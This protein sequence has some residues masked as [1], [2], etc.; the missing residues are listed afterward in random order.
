MA[1]EQYIVGGI[2]HFLGRWYTA[3]FGEYT[4]NQD[5]LDKVELKEYVDIL[6]GICERI[7]ASG[8]PYKEGILYVA[9]HYTK[10]FDEEFK[11]KFKKAHEPEFDTYMVDIF[12]MKGC[13]ASD[14]RY[15]ILDAVADYNKTF[16]SYSRNIGKEWPICHVLFFLTKLHNCISN[17]IQN[18]FIRNDLKYTQETIELIFNKN[19]QTTAVIA[20]HFKGLSKNGFDQ[21][22]QSLSNYTSPQPVTNTKEAEELKRKEAE[23]AEE[24]RK[25]A[26]E[27]KKKE[28]KQ[29]EADAQ[30][31]EERRRK[32]AEEQIRKE[33]EAKAAEEEERKRKEAEAAERK[34]KQA[35][36]LKQKEDEAAEEL[37]QQKQKEAKAKAAEEEK[38]K[39]KEAEAAKVIPVPQ[40]EETEPVIEPNIKKTPRAKQQSNTWTPI[41]K[42]EKKRINSA[43]STISFTEQN[44]H[45][46]NQIDV[47]NSFKSSYFILA[48]QGIFMGVSIFLI[49]RVG[50]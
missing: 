36:E 31:A 45:P 13:H 29:K 7:S 34:K 18:F 19:K 33:A 14:S 47:K 32:E 20:L 25:A 12:K 5:N 21:L 50:K 9:S 41:N 37:K 11:N 46:S 17:Y 8:S 3:E 39:Q 2:E 10:E 26:E 30:A 24:K 44:E 1:E 49:T 38:R 23:V 48:G 40:V 6:K 16:L 35:E 4:L 27:K 28:L 15:N 43:P 22:L 42:T